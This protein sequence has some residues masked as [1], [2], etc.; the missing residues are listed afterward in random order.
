MLRHDVFV[1]GAT[2]GDNV[3]RGQRS[4]YNRALRQFPDLPLNPVGNVNM[5]GMH[6]REVDANPDKLH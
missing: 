6:R 2:A 4:V 5:S 1:S 3:M